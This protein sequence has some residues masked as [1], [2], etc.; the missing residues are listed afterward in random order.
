MSELT[1]EYEYITEPIDKWTNPECN[2]L[3]E[4]YR[5][6]KS[7]VSMFQVHV[8][9]TL[10]E[11]IVKVIAN[12]QK[13]VFII[14]QSVGVSFEC[15][16]QLHR[17]QGNITKFEYFI[18]ENMFNV[19]YYS[20][21]DCIKPDGTLFLTTNPRICMERIKDRE[22]KGEDKIT[23]DYLNKLSEKMSIKPIGKVWYTIHLPLISSAQHA[24]SLIEMIC[25]GRRPET[26]EQ[27]LDRWADLLS[28]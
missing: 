10:M 17:E 7:I 13:K 15:F 2:L 26:E 20:C 14:E 1:Q 4:M 12:S 5:D 11:N 23:L 24:R 18:I 8:I 25:F 3:E 16:A 21:K 6:P 19:M 28:K 27:I 22:R 9:I